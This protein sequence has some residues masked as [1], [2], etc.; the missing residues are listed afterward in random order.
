MSV[1]GIFQ[2]NCF[3]FLSLWVGH[4]VS[5]KVVFR[6]LA[7]HCPFIV[8]IRP[9]SKALLKGVSLTTLCRVPA[10]LLRWQTWKLHRLANDTVPSHSTTPLPVTFACSRIDSSVIPL[11]STVNGCQWTICIELFAQ[12]ISQLPLCNISSSNWPTLHFP[13]M[14]SENIV[15]FL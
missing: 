1:G 2:K 4:K 11:P 8:A 7:Q 10:T 3:L 14:Q 15:C 6:S 12:V 5:N 9:K 13:L